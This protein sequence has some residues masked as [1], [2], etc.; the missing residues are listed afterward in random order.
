MIT[1]SLTA[2]TYKAINMIP[3]FGNAI[4]TVNT[5]DSVTLIV[6]DDSSFSSISYLLLKC[7][8]PFWLYPDTT[9]T[10]LTALQQVIL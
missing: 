4:I 7:D 3:V 6:I 2:P 5:T 8:W 10:I 1:L 9:T